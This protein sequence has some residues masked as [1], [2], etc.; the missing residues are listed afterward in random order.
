MLLYFQRE[1]HQKHMLRTKIVE[2]QVFVGYV[3][4]YSYIY[5]EN[6]LDLA[7]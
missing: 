3:K 7:A 1:P 2:I 4:G 5:P 6:M